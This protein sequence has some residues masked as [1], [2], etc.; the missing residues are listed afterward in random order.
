M[1]VADVAGQPVAQVESLSLRPADAGQFAAAATG[2][3]DALFTLGW[4]PVTATGTEDVPS[5]ADVTDA[6]A[7]AAD[8]SAAAV[9]FT[10][11]SG[12]RAPE[13]VHELAHRALAAVQL[14]LAEER[15]QDAPLVA[16]THG[17]V[18]AASGEDVPDLAGAAVW[19]LLRSAQT[20]NPGRIVLVDLDEGSAADPARQATALAAAIASG[21]PQ[22]AVRDGKLLAPR[23]HRAA[24]APAPAGWDPEGT[25]LLSGAT[26]A[27][28]A[29]V[30]RHLV[31]EHGVRHL[32]LTSRRG[33]QAPGAAELAA[34][35]AALGAE[36]TFAACDA[37]DAQAV[38]RVLAQIPATHPLRAVVHA[39]GVVD[40]G[41]IGALSAERVSGV[42]R[43][44][45]DAAWN[46]HRATAHLDL[47]AFVLFSSVAG[48]Y[49]TAGQAAYAAGNAFLDA[50]AAHRR[51]QGLTATSLAWGPWAEGGM[52]AQLS[53]ADQAR[54]ARTGMKEIEPARGLALFDAALALDTAVAVPV[55]LDTGAL[56]A[57][58]DE[59][60]ALMR[61]L[62]RVP[63]RRAA[64]T[65]AATPLAQRLAGRPEA[66]QREILVELVRAQIAAVLNFEDAAGVDARRGFK[67]LGL[68]SLTA[69]ELRNRLGKES[70]LR[71]P[72]TLVFDYPSA[73]A[74]ADHLL[75]ELRSAQA[76]AAAAGRGAAA[77]AVRDADEPIAIVGMAC[78]YPGG[79]RSPE[80]LWQLVMG[81]G[82][83]ISEFPADR[84]WDVANLF[85]PDP[86]R[87]G[88]SY[89]REGGFLHDV[90]DFDAEFFGISPRE[91]LA[92]DPQQR[93]LLETSWEAL[94]RAGIDPAALRGSDTGVFT[95]VMYHD[96]VS[97]LPEMPGDLEG[98]LGT[99]NTGSVSSG[100]ISYTF[101]FEG[102]A[103]SVD[104]ACS[105][106]L[107][108][109]HLAIQ[110][111]R[112]G[113]CSLA[114]AGGVTV[115][116]SPFTFIEFSRQRAL[117]P[118]GRS[119]SFS[120]DADG[121]GWAEGAGMLLV[122]RLSD[123][124]RLGHQVLAVVRGSA[125]NQDGASN[126]L[127]APNGPSQQRV[128]RAAL[129]SARLT[130]A[131]V[132]AVEA[133]GTGTPLGDPI[134]A[135]ALQATYGQERAGEEPLWLGSVKSNIGHTQAAA[136]AASVIKMVQ[137]LQHGVLPQ[138]L[139]AETPSAIVDW[140][141]GAVEL[142]AEARQWPET[143]RPRRAGVSS[144]GISGTNA[145]VILEQ[146]PAEPAATAEEPP[147]DAAERAEVALR[148]S[149]TTPDALRDQARQLA[150]H[151]SL[152]PELRRTDVAH[153][154]A[155][156]R[157]ALPQRAVVLGDGLDALSRG[158]SSPWVV[159]A[160]A[161]EW[162][163][164]V[165]VLP[166]QGS[167]WH[168][169][170]VE[171][172]DTTPVFADRLRQ[173]AAVVE[174]YVPW[175]VEAV[176]RGE[177]EAPSLE[178]IEV[179]Q[180][181]LFA[182]NIA[183]A[184]VW[185]A[186]GIHPDAVIGHSQGEI[187]AAHLSGALTLEDAARIV[188]VRS[189]IFADEL[190]G[191]GA[192]ASLQMTEDDVLPH[193]A[194]Y[195]GRL[196]IAGVNGPTAVTVAGD[197]DALEELVTSVTAEGIRARIVPSTVAS[198]SP[199]VEPLRER[200]L[201]ALDFVQPTK[202][203]LPQYSTVNGAV[204]DGTELTAAYWYENC[205]QPVSFAPTLHTLLADGHTTFIET[206]AHPVLT[207]AIEEIVD[208]A[209]G[210]ALVLATLRRGE[211]GPLRLNTSLAEAWVRGLP[212]RP[213]VPARPRRV[214][215]PTYPFQRKRYWVEAAGDR[216]AGGTRDTVEAG[217]W[218]AVEN[219]DLEALAATLGLKDGEPLGAV[220]PALADWRQG[221]AA[222]SAA[223]AW[224]YKAVWRPV[225]EPASVLLSGTWLLV[226]PQ[227][228][229]EAAALADR[230]AKTL[231][232][233]GAD[234]VRLDAGPAPDRAE[235]AQ[236]IGTST[237]GGV[238]GV[239][240]LLAL[241]ETPAA[242]RP[243]LTEGTAGTLLLIQALADAGVTAPLWALTQGAVGAV[244][245]EAPASPAQAQVWALGRTAAVEHPDRW[246]GLVDLPAD[247]DDRALAR[248]AAAVSGL[249]D[250]D[251]LAVRDAGMLARRLVRSPLASVPVR[252]TWKPHGTVLVTGG[253]RGMGGHTARRLAE[254][255]AEHLLL[256]AERE[257][258]PAEQVALEAEFAAAGVRVSVAVCDVADREALAAVLA[259]V[260][261]DAPLTAVVHT[262]GELDAAPLGDLDP[263]ALERALRTRTLG[264]ANLDE[265]LRETELEAFVLFSSLAG[266]WGSATQGGYGAAN[267][268]V[269]ALAARR[270]GLGLPATSVAWG[271]WGDAGAGL[272]DEEAEA[273]RLAQ[274]RRRGVAPL[275][276]RQAVA[277]LVEAVARDED[278]L[279]LADVDW[280]LFAPALTAVRSSPLLDELP[281]AARALAGSAPDATAA[282]SATQDLTQ[283]LAGLSPTDQE[284]VLTDLVRTESA[285]VLGH[286]D[287]EAVDAQR[288]LQELGFDSLAAV[289]L[290][291]RLGAV[292]GLK[293]PATLV[294][295]HPTP[296]AVAA[297]LRGELLPEQAPVSLDAE[298]DRLQE[299]LEGSGLADD[300]AARALV[301][302]RLRRLLEE[303]A[304]E[305][306]AAG[307]RLDVEDQLASASD[308]D[309][310]S[311]I[312]NELG[313]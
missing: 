131:D 187:A 195:T 162:G 66:E 82:D 44:K 54:L 124:R 306:S 159:T 220:L 259:S 238:S 75:A 34:E 158:E 252:R 98:Y 123:A 42:L 172:L 176:L 10:S 254:L 255:G 165:F 190:T 301:A 70:G 96:Y 177:P 135:Q 81:R 174:R 19:G 225:A 163:R 5:Y 175:R 202:A 31:A 151:L 26:G 284:R 13:S 273:E 117:S 221:A 204:L 244:G 107:V 260:P 265:L 251:Q 61:S 311:F 41:V 88:T 59:L 183:L 58:G 291:N 78:R 109:L 178:R 132:D 93:L 296:A 94:E 263:A 100:R 136:G 39:A 143:G 95:G 102:P 209:Q 295:N 264:A 297:F 236:N 179:L 289:T 15:T 7:A 185:Q 299:V 216:P 245:A 50:L 304:D 77:R 228:H 196:W 146:A 180:P 121:T 126:G 257:L 20:E 192:V 22:L 111:L 12:A 285:V 148:L 310:F 282:A 237:S 29:L 152:H 199:K 72:A 128:I 83:A 14:W 279:V 21:E 303:V 147:E 63:A 267:A 89:T 232:R 55:A 90:A 156:T 56:G 226:A 308:D 134:E 76:P 130:P 168:G 219:R 53:A 171:L 91:A 307:A 6:L 298:L 84:G 193:L 233:H 222:R 139:H 133:H 207:T 240:S 197:N 302:A 23:L 36:A 290:R 271:P 149:A 51:A 208:A 129:N 32:L 283:S 99:G 211:G 47:S 277:A 200:L 309:I 103:V 188:V 101:G 253:T 45:A 144:F 97:R 65:A 113:E 235:L 79:V 150:A 292:T 213:P 157:A 80:D 201:A 262:A 35:L 214:D 210:E 243:A 40:D 258:E 287:S 49:G 85:D 60:P 120:A 4:V 116:S 3:R 288:P 280:E 153:A 241:D 198:H 161:R 313:Q 43:P 1:T 300:A 112:S 87:P 205:R 67:D 108:A 38:E 28:G 275:S 115:L 247:P 127:T 142:L 250:E 33:G 231:E 48:T 137:A 186:H 30:A 104:T 206:S 170:A 217:F 191:H 160:T 11:A 276:S 266:V 141:A 114:L 73:A 24:P 249:A 167:Q 248:L 106:S 212:V 189:Q 46:L 105:S 154:L 256:T 229:A 286:S 268:H 57:L 18:A 234:V 119:R 194:P 305:P 86:D 140:D 69:V 182:V 239:V 281:E 64:T 173:C 215:L 164:T 27:L 169:M 52:A 294:F 261:D 270:R 9:R 203:T 138:T 223:D 17:A 74:V 110:A 242:G 92:M 312:D 227:G 230:T 155:T 62:V 8:G 278:T 68:D 25:V 71:L 184:A 272:D 166:G 274:L 224:R 246:G 16:V 269:D 118:T 181:V 125:V 2:P 218:E 37:S 293:L 145:H 122:E